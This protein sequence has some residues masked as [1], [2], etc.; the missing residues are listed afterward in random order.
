MNGPSQN[1]QFPKGVYRLFYPFSIFPSAPTNRF[2][3]GPFLLNIRLLSVR[4]SLCLLICQLTGSSIFTFV[5]PIIFGQICLTL[6]RSTKLSP[7]DL[8]MDDGNRKEGF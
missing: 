6:I 2:N 4:L 5:Y 3:P 7:P 1:C 8:G